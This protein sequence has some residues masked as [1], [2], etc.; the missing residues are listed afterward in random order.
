MGCQDLGVNINFA[1]G[2]SQNMCPV[3][4]T[5]ESPSLWAPDHNSSPLN[6]RS[7]CRAKRE[8][9]Q[10]GRRGHPEGFME[11]DS[12]EGGGNGVYGCPP[13]SRDTLST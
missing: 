12:P 6:G 1:Q 4:V 7:V 3:E 5:E 8:S 9:R 10:E 13:Q 2:H 11:G